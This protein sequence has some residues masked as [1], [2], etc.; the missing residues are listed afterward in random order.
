M[1]EIFWKEVRENLKWAV[2]L[3]CIV[4]AGTAYAL[5]QFLPEF[6]WVES[7]AILTG[8]ASAAGGLL[9]GIL[10][11]A[12]ESSKDRRAFI[13][14]RPVPLRDIFLGK[15]LAGL[16]LLYIA[17]GLPY[18]FS[19][20]WSA[21]SGRTGGPFYLGMAAPGVLD[22]LSGAMYWFAGM[23]IGLR[24]ARWYGSRILVLGLPIVCTS[25]TWI[26]PEYWQAALCILAGT[27]V[28]A[29]AA[30]GTF[31]AGGACEP[32][33]RISRAAL[34]LHVF[35]GMAIVGM[36]LFSFLSDF[37][38]ERA[39]PE[40][41][42]HYQVQ[43]D[44][45]ILRVQQNEDGSQVVADLGGKTLGTYPDSM[46]FRKEWPN[47]LR[48]DS[49]WLPGGSN[50]P[51]YRDPRR[52]VSV[53]FTVYHP[54]ERWLF[55]VPEGALL[56]YDTID[57]RFLGSFGPEGFSPPSR[58]PSGRFSG[59]PA[60][61]G[62]TGALSSPRGDYVVLTD[63]IWQF[64]PRNR[65]IKLFFKVDAS[66]PIRCAMMLSSRQASDEPRFVVLSRTSLIILDGSGRKVLAAALPAGALESPFVDLG[67]LEETNHFI[68]SYYL[69]AGEESKKAVYLECFQ[70]IGPQGL[71][72]EAT[73]LP[74]QSSPW[75]PSSYDRVAWTLVPL[76]GGPVGTFAC[77]VLG[78]P[79]THLGRS[80]K[81]YPEPSAP[82]AGLALRMLAGSIISAGVTFAILR[83]HAP[84]KVRLVAWTLGNFL[85]GGIG[86]LLLWCLAEW[87]AL[88][89]CPSCSRKRVVTRETCEHCGAPFPPP[90]RDG[91]EILE[92]AGA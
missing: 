82:W 57:K 42:W 58:S 81:S 92:P 39:R 86:L 68:V 29:A 48:P 18:L 4:G 79:Y 80:L 51:R 45:T 19:V 15:A 88:E 37:L 14:H 64:E 60:F 67:R 62:G 75:R 85:L 20:A 11:V 72:G 89:K 26:V 38:Q 27:G 44:G 55:S 33:P 84:S 10:Q 74:V 3:F 21:F 65:S 52:F 2:L 87:P 59:Q 90:A 25:L 1:K 54:Q 69:R 50:Y 35:A 56:G 91:T 7:T 41:S 63:S 6:Y 83:R 16:G 17:V 24:Q 61:F 28:S 31:R 49:L 40:T 77:I 13:V 23:L 30:W 78:D 9:L 46:A 36:L 43:S 73:E 12:F 22:I 5:R 66:D 76:G 70:K 34:G 32:Q 47:L 8:A 53:A 71:I